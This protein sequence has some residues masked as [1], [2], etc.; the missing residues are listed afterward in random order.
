MD[1]SSVY[2]LC[3]KLKSHLLNDHTI[4]TQ[5]CSG[6]DDSLTGRNCQFILRT[7]KGT[8]LLSVTKLAEDG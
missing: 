4:R 7:D 6:V 5:F 2:E 8:Y 1:F 3:A